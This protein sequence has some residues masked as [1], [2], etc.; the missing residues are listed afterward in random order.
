MIN[1]FL[2]VIVLPLHMH[3][4]AW[5]AMFWTH[6]PWSLHLELSHSREDISQFGP[7]WPRGHSQEYLPLVSMHVLFLAKQSP[8]PCINKTVMFKEFNS[9]FVVYLLWQGYVPSASRRHF[10]ASLQAIQITIRMMLIVQ[11]LGIFLVLIRL[12]LLNSQTDKVK[13]MFSVFEFSKMKML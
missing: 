5:L 4:N 13:K 9:R 2:I 8:Q 7:V 1:G 3:V 10:V 12:C 6:F 11:N